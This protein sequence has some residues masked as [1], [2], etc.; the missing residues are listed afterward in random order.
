MSW[1]VNVKKQVVQ[2]LANLPR[3]IQEALESDICRES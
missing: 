2:G 3:N 1:K